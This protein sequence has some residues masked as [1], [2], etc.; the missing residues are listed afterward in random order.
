MALQGPT[1]RPASGDLDHEANGRSHRHSFVK[2][3]GVGASGYLVNL[4][5]YI[6][7]TRIVGVATA[8]AASGAFLVATSSNYLWNRKWTFHVPGPY[9]GVQ[10][11]GFLTLASV[12]LALNILLLD[13][14]VSLGVR[15]IE[16]QAAAIV[17]VTP[18]NYLGS[19]ALFRE[20]VET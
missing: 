17:F 3:C 18:L 13:M 20:H 10:M 7:L 5:V 12:C 16:A 2:F 6:S 11:I 8:L 19:R 15:A 4:G 14:L 9:H 1:A